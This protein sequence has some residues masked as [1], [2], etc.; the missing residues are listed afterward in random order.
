MAQES[1]LNTN[2]N[3]GDELTADELNTHGQEHQNLGSS[4]GFATGVIGPEA[5][6]VHA[7]SYDPG[8]TDFADGLVDRE[9]N[10]IALQPG[11]G[12]VVERIEFRNQGGATAAAASV[13]VRDATAGED[14]G[15]ASLGETTK[16]PGGSNTGST[17]L[18]QVTNQTG[19]AITAAPRVQA[20]ITGV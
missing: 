18:V 20:Y 10:R 11:E 4:G 7:F 3:S 13:T 12:L 19:N 5:L 1:L 2:W 14:I 15:G 17:V 9:V 6:S 16:G 8:M